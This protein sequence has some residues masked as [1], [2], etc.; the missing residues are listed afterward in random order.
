LLKNLNILERWIARAHLLCLLCLVLAWSATKISPDQYSFLALFGLA[1]PLTAIFNLLFAGY[2]IYRKKWFFILSLGF[3]VLFWN[4]HSHWFQFPTSK[5]NTVG[6]KLMSYNVRIFDLYEWLNKKGE[7]KQ[8]MLDLFTTENPEV[9]CFQEYMVNANDSTNLWSD[10]LKHHLGFTHQALSLIKPEGKA[11]R[12]GLATFSKHPI[13][14]IQPLALNPNSMPFAQVVDIKTHKGNFLK[15]INVHLASIHFKDED[16]RFIKNLKEQENLTRGGIQI[17]NRL[18]QAF[19]IR[20]QQVALIKQAIN[21]S[22]YPTVV[23]GDF[24]D[25]PVS[26]SYAQ[27]SENMHDAFM[28]SGSGTGTTYTGDFPSFRIDY[29]L[30]SNNIKSAN[31]N[32]I[33][34]ELSDHYPITVE[35]DVLRD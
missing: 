11:A 4:M 3:I 15:V 2:W 22:P 17:V 5:T 6:G 34:K 7:T 20:A 28:V 19:E 23:V 8:Q 21:N 24:N 18:L 13:K 25:S 31:F 32:I 12:Y 30:H 10:T 27:L 16:Y 1:F 33:K 29:I 26:Y 35:L 9:I 14:S